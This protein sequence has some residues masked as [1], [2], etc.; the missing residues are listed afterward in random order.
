ME[1]I[2]Q[3]ASQFSEIWKRTVNSPTLQNLLGRLLRGVNALRQGRGDGTSQRPPSA[4]R[5]YTAPT[6][7]TEKRT[8][9]MTELE[10]AWLYRERPERSLGALIVED[11]YGFS[12]ETGKQLYQNFLD[13]WATDKGLPPWD[14]SQPGFAYQGGNPDWYAEQAT[15]L[16]ASKVALKAAEDVVK[17]DYASWAETKDKERLVFAWTWTSSSRD[18]S[19]RTA[20]CSLSRPRACWTT[21]HWPS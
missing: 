5:M 3:A 7:S 2:S 17:A 1:Q 21:R 4:L 16:K 14:D 20:R 15:E 18:A 11:L 9:E 19:R 10:R 12:Y 8:R 6:G 13:E